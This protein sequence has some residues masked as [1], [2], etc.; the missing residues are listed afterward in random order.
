MCTYF[1]AYRHESQRDFADG[2]GATSRALVEGLFGIQPDAL[3]GSLTVRPGFPMEWE[4]ASIRHPDLDFD[5]QRTNNRETFVLNQRFTEPMKLKLRLAAR[6]TKP[7]GVTVNGERSAIKWIRDSAHSPEIEIEA[8][9]QAT[10][11]VMVAWDGR[12]STSAR[13][14]QREPYA[15]PFSPVLPDPVT[16][17]SHEVTHETIDLKPVFN[18]RVTQIFRNEYL[19][20]RSPFCSL[21][22]PKQ[23]IGSWC[24]PDTTF[25]VDDSG[26]RSLAREGHGVL[27]IP[28]GVSFETPADPGVNN[29]AFVSQWDNFPD[30]L[31]VPVSGRAS[32]ASLLMAGST[33]PMQSRIDNGE[34]VFTYAD[35]TIDRLPL[36]NPTTWWPI[37]QDYFIDDYAFQLK[38]PL[39]TRVDLKTGAVRVLE[40]DAFKGRGGTVPGGAATVLELPLD[41]GRELESLTL[42]ALANEVVIGLMSVTLTR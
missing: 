9:P 25:D 8:A 33:G 35:G 17:P 37:D 31:S 11:Q 36:H 29:I 10:V 42:R 19:T 40:R 39:P 20:P 12:R 22:T 28:N 15:I 14:G 1:D 24:L 13:E 26:L 5:F 7:K 23:G 18:D 4:Y 3:A 2:V 38:G 34:V 16:S 21:A 6:G 41:P 27:R 30:E 32:R